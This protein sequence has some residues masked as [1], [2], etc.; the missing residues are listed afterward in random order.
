MLLVEEPEAH[1]HPQLTMLL[2]EHLAKTTPG[3]SAPQTLVTTHSP[4]LAAN[5]PP[6]RVHVLFTDQERKKP[7]CNSVATA[8]MDENEQGELQRMMDITRATLYF[9]KAVILVEGISES[10]L[11]PVLAK[12]LGHNLAKEHVSVIPI[13][14]VAFETFKKL[15]DRHVLG[16]PV[17]VVSDADPRVMRGRDWNSDAAE[18]DG[19][20]FKLCDRMNKLLGI[21][22]GHASVKVF[23]S[24][25]TLEYDLAEAGDGNAA[26]MAAVWESCF[27]G[28]PG[29]FNM[30]KVIEAGNSR[31]DKA[32]AA[33]RGICR[34]DHS[35]SKAEFAHRLSAKLSEQQEGGQWTTAFVAPQYIVEAIEYVVKAL[36]PP[37]METGDTAQ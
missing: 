34:A 9:A 31:T 23:H 27:V 25:L 7:C 21:F 10:L 2:A 37:V 4:T 16:I 8:G 11:I 33:W 24:K 30:M 14:G 15:L 5:V 32:L 22:N 1:L 20:V 35:G 13:C 29:T 26:V 19:A 12:R 17:A 28:T 18:T 6:N 36:N 3:A